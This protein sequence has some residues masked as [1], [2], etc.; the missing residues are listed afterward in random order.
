MPCVKKISQNF[1]FASCIGKLSENWEQQFRFKIFSEHSVRQLK[2][3]S[4]SWITSKGHV[5]V[6]FQSMPLFVLDLQ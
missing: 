1:V 3:D 4:K 6:Q 2:T 5:L